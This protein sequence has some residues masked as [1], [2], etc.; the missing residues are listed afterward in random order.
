MVA[1][2]PLAWQPSLLGGGAPAAGRPVAGAHRRRLGE[3]AWVDLVPGWLAGADALVAE[4]LATVDWQAREVPMYGQVV[5]QPRLSAFWPAGGCPEVLAGLAD[6]LSE[7]YGLD[8]GSV[9]ANLYRDGHDSVAFHGDRHARGVDCP[10]TVVPV[11]TLGATRR[12]LLRPAG[13][14]PSVVLRPGSGDLLV[15]GGSCQRTW[16]HAV[17]KTARNVG[18]RLSVTFRAVL[19]GAAQGAALASP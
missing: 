4:L 19:S 13:G 8:L 18:P 1:T 11:L 9:G 2:P 14:G 5:P 15:M 16:Q 10:D 3:G 7:H 6:R 17:P 12:F